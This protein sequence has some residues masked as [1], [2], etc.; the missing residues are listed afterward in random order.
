[1]TLETQSSK[2][3]AQGNGATVNWPYTFPIPSESELVITIINMTTGLTSVL[4]PTLFTVTGIG[5]PSGGTVTYPLSG[6]PLSVAYT[7][8]I[9]RVVPL[10]QETDL[11]NQGGAYP[12]DI[13]DALDYLT[14][15]TQ[16]MEEVLDRTVQFPVSDSAIGT[17]PPVDAR[18]NKFFSFDSDGQPTASG[19]ITSSV[20][21][22]AAMIPVVGAST[23]AAALVQLG[24]LGATFETRALAQ[25]ALIQ[26][27]VTFIVT[28]GYTTAG[29]GGGG[30]YIRTGATSA[31]GFQSADGQWWKLIADLE[32]RAEQFGAKGDNV[33][34]D[35]AAL[36][37]ARD[38]CYLYGTQLRLGPHTYRISA[39]FEI[40]QGLVVR[41]SG[42][43][44]TRVVSTALASD[45]FLVTA[46]LG[47]NVSGV[48]IHDLIVDSS[49]AKSAGYCIRVRSLGGGIFFCKF[50]DL[51]FDVRTFSG[52]SFE[53]GFNNRIE[54][55]IVAHI[56]A[57]GIGFNLTGTSALLT[58]GNLLISRCQVLTGVSAVGT[59]GLIVDS[60]AEGIYAD[61][62]VF[63]S[64]GI[65]FNIWIRNTKG[66]LYNPRNL[67]FSD[68][69]CD[70]STKGS[71]LVQSG[72]QINFAN[73]WLA[74]G[75]T[76]AE[77]VDAISI[78]FVGC[79]FLSIQNYGVLM[80]AGSSFIT[81]SNCVFDGISWVTPN[82]T[83]AIFVA[84]N[85]S[86]FII[87]DNNF[88]RLGQFHRYSVLV[89]AG[90]SDR[91]IISHNNLYGY[92]TGAIFDLGAGVNKVVG[93]NIT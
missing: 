59:A 42:N 86:D 38:Y 5:G 4:N 52:V 27:A 56:G 75:L 25:V 17:L 83:D 71:V 54:N 92:L 88:S 77:L 9:Q 28:V 16:Q 32:V 19:A 47:T 89:S 51:Y 15:I 57:N 66:A 29:D 21:V 93:S 10:T 91:Y 85:V 84:P 62:C 50:S 35:L 26:S 61:H 45:V 2:A 70:S 78:R 90:T 69:I 80:R 11:I 87:T 49:A 53:V 55:I 30:T 67:F 24:L 37:S 82:T 58:M 81:V 13:E 74:G 65:D 23:V 64:S 14:M 36:E 1:M 18:A 46:N 76:G 34:D 43:Q 22:S 31:G 40:T 39:T 20:A 6:S 68:M 7:I 60:W 33:T 12:A 63:E 79:Q 8:T 44:I 48:E 3:V 72:F 41:G 73:C